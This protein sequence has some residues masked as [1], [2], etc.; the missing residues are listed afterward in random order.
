MKRNLFSN[1]DIVRS[2]HQKLDVNENAMKTVVTLLKHIKNDMRQYAFHMQM[3]SVD[4]SDYF[5]LK[6]AEVNINYQ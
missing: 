4:M 6:N 2:N 3:D 5:P 1:S